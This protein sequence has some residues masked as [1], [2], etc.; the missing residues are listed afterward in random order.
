MA[1]KYFLLFFLLLLLCCGCDRQAEPADL[2]QPPDQSPA[3]AE[4]E[5]AP[6]TGWD[7]DVVP[8]N[9]A[10]FTRAQMLEDYDYF[11]SVLE[12]NCPLLPLVG[13]VRGS[14]M[15]SSQLK[16]F[17]RQKVLALS[18]G[19]AEGFCAAME[20]VC[21]QFH[22]IGHIGV[23]SSVGPH[24]YF[25]RMEQHNDENSPQLWEIYTSEKAQAFYN[26]QIQLPMYRDIWE[27][28]TS[29][30]KSDLSPEKEAQPADSPS[31]SFSQSIPVLKIP[32]FSGPP[33]QRIDQ[34]KSL[35]LEQIQAP[36]L[37]LDLRGNVGGNTDIWLKGL[38]PLFQGKDLVQRSLVAYINSSYNRQIWGE[39]AC[40]TVLDP[41]SQPIEQ[42]FSLSSV[43][44]E[45]LNQ[46]DLALCDRFALLLS[47][48]LR[49]EPD[50]KPIFQGR[51]WILTDSNVYSGAEA[52]VQFAQSSGL[53]TVVGQNTS[54]NGTLAMSPP[55]IPF[56]LP[57]SGMIAQ[58]TPFYPINPDGS[59]TE[60]A[61]SSPDIDAGTEDALEVCLR[62]IAKEK[63]K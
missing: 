4:P 48:T 46:E 37:I 40:Q 32:S 61:G 33:Q 60:L 35:C 47:M 26:W 28:Q 15:D 6:E 31:L 63:T 57:N 45:N 38:Y 42:L 49:A 19:D 41:A 7:A 27:S 62:E 13:R 43:Q 51:L 24:S 50:A 29:R 39:K 52:F 30:Q 59:C 9:P 34:L 23:I 44:T 10:G 1:K 18:D 8:F 55:K 16:E 36:D 58:Y 56:L 22:Q 21:S 2:E 5:P 11:W 3:P 20:Y 14:S 53:A 12:E 25:L 17:G 54:G